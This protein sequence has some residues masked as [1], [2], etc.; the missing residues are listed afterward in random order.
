[1]G[2]TI[3]RQQIL[4]RKVWSIHDGVGTAG[5]TCTDYNCASLLL[6]GT[7]YAEATGTLWNNLDLTDAWTMSLW[8][9]AD[10]SQSAGA[11][12]FINIG[13]DSGAWNDNIFRLYF[14][15]G[16]GALNRLIAEYRTGSAR[17]QPLWPLHSHNTTCGLGSNN[18]VG[19]SATNRGYKNANDFTLL[20][21]TYDPT[22]SA[23]LDQ[24]RFKMYWNG[25][26]LGGAFDNDSN[27]QLVTFPTGLAKKFRIGATIVTNTAGMEGNLDEI[28]FFS[29]VLTPTEVLELWNGTQTPGST[30]GTPNNL[31][32]HS[33]A[34]DLEAWYRGENNL[35]DSSTNS[36]TL[37]NNGTTFDTTNK[38]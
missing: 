33:R 11:R 22:L 16:G 17:C 6:G 26:D 32:S 10:W 38:A 21:V 2:T 35:L 37:T 3:N 4:S 1:M 36:N 14:T 5:A 8:V 15:N 28:S 25:N 9:R 23:S 19:W 34:G 7:D 24:V 27:P 13:D 20:T 30:D 31:L 18:N 12:I 29:G